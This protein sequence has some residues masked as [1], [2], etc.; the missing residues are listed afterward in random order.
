MITLQDVLEIH[1][2]QIQEHGGLLGLR[3]E[4]ALLAALERPF[5]GFG[6]Y[7]F[8]PTPQ[9]KAAA[10]LESLIINH[11][12]MDGNKRTGYFI[13]R[14]VL[15]EAGVD[16]TADQEERY[17]FVISVASGMTSYEEIVNWIHS[18]SGPANFT[19]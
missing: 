12:F 8:Y 17:R 16:L 1:T 9:G 7:E 10:V 14:L 11:P 15:L 6:D 5:G 13:M 3:D 4:G 18:N 19:S 2:L